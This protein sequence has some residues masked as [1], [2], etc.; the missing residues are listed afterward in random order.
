M[1][2]AAVNRIRVIHE[3]MNGCKNLKNHLGIASKMKLKCIA[4][5]GVQTD[6]QMERE[7]RNYSKI[8]YNFETGS[9]FVVKVTCII[10][11][12]IVKGMN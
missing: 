3:P 6:F 7:V 2:L 12:K 11:L 8:K 5:N 1:R 4:L 10:N 9:G